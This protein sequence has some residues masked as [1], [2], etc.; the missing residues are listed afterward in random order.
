ML[1][2]PFTPLYTDLYEAP[3]VKWIFRLQHSPHF[4]GYR[5]GVDLHSLARWPVC[6]AARAVNPRSPEG[7]AEGVRG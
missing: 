7:H 4:L 3:R 2:G 1:R 6:L 5:R